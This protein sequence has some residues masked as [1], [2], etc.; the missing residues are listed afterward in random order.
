MPA[1]IQNPSLPDDQA[2]AA[3]RSAPKDR[4][5]K[6][7]VALVGLAEAHTRA[8]QQTPNRPWLMNYYD[9]MANRSW[10]P[11]GQIAQL[12]QAQGRKVIG[13]FCVFAPDE[14]I[15]AAGGLPIRL[16]AGADEAIPEGEQELG[17]VNI[18]PVIKSSLG[19][20]LL[21]MPFAGEA[22]IDLALIPTVCDG[23]KKL[24]DIFARYVPTWM[25]QVPHTSLDPRVRDYWR[26]E[27]K[28][29]RENLEEF[30]G[31]KIKAKELAGAI[32]LFNRKR[33]VIRRLYEVRQAPLPPITGRDALLVVST[34]YHDDPQRWVE[35]TERLC[36][37]LE[38]R[39]RRGIGVAEPHA[40]RLM[41]AGCPIVPPNWKVPDILEELGG[42][43]VTDEL[44]T[45]SRG[46][47]YLVGEEGR[48]VDEMVTALADR[49][50]MCECPC[51]VPNTPRLKRIVES[52][53]AWRVKGVIYYQLLFCHTLNIE[54]VEV[55]RALRQ[56][57]IPMCK[58]DTDYS[59]QGA[60]AMRTRLESFLETL[61]EDKKQLPAK[62]GAVAQAPSF[63]MSL[64][65]PP[66]L[67]GELP[68]VAAG[69]IPSGPLSRPRGQTVQP[70]VLPAI[71][72]PA[73][74]PAA[75]VA[76]KPQAAATPQPVSPPAAQ[77]G[78]EPL[79]TVQIQV[80]EFQLVIPGG[81]TIS[82]AAGKDYTLGRGHSESPAE[83][84]LSEYGGDVSQVSRKHAR[85]AV[86]RDRCLLEDLGSKNGTLV[87]GRR[88]SPGERCPL[89][90]EEQITLGSLILH[91]LKG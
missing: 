53:E 91:V 62:P 84:D 17:T 89:S 48:S 47:W 58:I 56:I 42:I 6:V 35:Q 74:P 4:Q 28:L 31:H 65:L 45:G 71:P 9:E 78:S 57:G 66:G 85:L 24:V 77:P 13:T 14:L 80:G 81:R 11:W 1:D 19:L 83:I 18:C 33:R 38:D 87:N 32:Q 39:V 23:K 72:A 88:L 73:P 67:A 20:K 75:P 21:N 76:Q 44:C 8:M 5:E 60:E 7:R 86:A 25:L 36:L 69:H 40:S 12:A 15:Y 49:Y 70:Q 55:E 22:R 54:A 3:V 51:F 10:D 50:I 41:L 30:T 59:E 37:E 63:W 26:T 27:I 46:Y 82:L 52:V 16:D 34:S 61:R 64:T 43:I 79:P 2:D 29:L 68:T 90:G